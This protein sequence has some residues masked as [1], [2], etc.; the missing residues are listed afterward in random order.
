MVPMCRLMIVHKKVHLLRLH[1]VFL[2]YIVCSMI[3]VDY[4]LTLLL[5]IDEVYFSP[6]PFDGPLGL[7]LHQAPT[8]LT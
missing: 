5:V 8:H 3:I 7:S 6:F 1:N 4:F 2:D